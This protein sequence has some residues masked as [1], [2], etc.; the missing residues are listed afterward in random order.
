MQNA[1][2]YRKALNQRFSYIGK[3]NYLSYLFR[4]SRVHES[5]SVKRQASGHWGKIDTIIK[6]Y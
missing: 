3:N 6:R 1:G 5:D 2:M 4:V